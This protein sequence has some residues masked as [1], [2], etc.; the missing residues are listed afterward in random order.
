M[1]GMEGRKQGGEV[2]RFKR[3]FKS[4]TV[5]RGKGRGQGGN[6]NF[7]LS[8][9]L[10]SEGTWEGSVSF[11]LFC[12]VYMTGNSQQKF[13]EQKIDWSPGSRLTG[14]SDL[15]AISRRLNLILQTVRKHYG[16]QLEKDIPVCVLERS[17]WWLCK[18]KIRIGWKLTRKVF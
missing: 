6:P 17:V 7:W 5:R 16:F 18:G 9:Q 13:R 3:Y 8:S 4:R 12:C 1:G 14:V 10:L 15:Q 11:P 2:G